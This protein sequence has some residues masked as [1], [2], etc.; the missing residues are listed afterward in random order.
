MNDET[1][2]AR[3]LSGVPD[4]PASAIARFRDESRAGVPVLVFKKSP[5]CP[6][7]FA[8][9]AAYRAFL[10]GW[11]RPLKTLEIDVI[12]QKPLARGLTAELGIRHE[13][14]QALVFRDGELVWHDSHEGLNEEAFRRELTAG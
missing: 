3:D 14:P 1:T 12:A 9:E 7:S 6:V 13:S 10:G 11:D 4:D 2:T 8:A 5:I